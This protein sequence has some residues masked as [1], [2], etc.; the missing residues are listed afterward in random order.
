ML[1]KSDNWCVTDTVQFM[2]SNGAEC[3]LEYDPEKVL[4]ELNKRINNE[5]TCDFIDKKS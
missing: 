4:T 1:L 5:I 3:M 2:A